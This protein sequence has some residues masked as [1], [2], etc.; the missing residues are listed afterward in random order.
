MS[1]NYGPKMTGLQYEALCRHAIS[2]LYGVPVDQIHGG[3]LLGVTNRRQK[4]RHQIDLYWTASDGVCEYKVFANAKWRVDSVDM[5]DVM[6]LIGVWRDIG[7]HKAMIITNSE[8]DIGVRKQAEEKGIALLI[9][10]PCVDLGGLGVKKVDV[11]VQEVEKIAAERTE[12][13]FGFEVVHK[14]WGPFDGAQGRGME[15]GKLKME[16]EAGA[17][18]ESGAVE[19]E[20]AEEQGGMWL[21]GG[22]GGDGEVEGVENKAMGTGE[23]PNKMM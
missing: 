1:E 23:I 7:M 6:E 13:V 18:R 20:S 16:N 8:F 22:G 3:H 11:V 12:P 10:R 15:N 4:T 5:A 2:R 17:S 14:G 19:G 21:I 9:V